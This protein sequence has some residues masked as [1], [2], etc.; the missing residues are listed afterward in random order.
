MCWRNGDYISAGGNCIYIYIITI[1]CY[2]GKHIE[3]I[4]WYLQTFS[5]IANFDKNNRNLMLRFIVYFGFC[6]Y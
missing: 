3:D 5:V 6:L 4:K 2:P 1:N